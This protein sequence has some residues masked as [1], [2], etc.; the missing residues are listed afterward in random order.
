MYVGSV[1]QSEQTTSV[2]SLQAL[3]TL[4]GLRNI[5]DKIMGATRG[6][7]IQSSIDHSK[8]VDLFLSV[9]GSY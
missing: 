4:A 5:E 6:Q 7:I 9:M 3:R 2:K 8:V 1:L